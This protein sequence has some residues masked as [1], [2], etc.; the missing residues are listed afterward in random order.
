MALKK[1]STRT[2]EGYEFRLTHDDV[3]D[4]M[5]DQQVQLNNGN[6]SE[7]QVF[8]FSLIKG[9]GAGGEIRL[10]QFKPDDTL[11]FRFNVV[12]QDGTAETVND[13]DVVA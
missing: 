4:L 10:R 8:E 6:V 12:T 13:L 7:D 9:T 5:N 3:V 2:T 11:I 1:E